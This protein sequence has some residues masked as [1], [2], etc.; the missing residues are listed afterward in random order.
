MALRFV[1][2][3]PGRSGR[4]LGGP[5]PAEGFELS[6]CVLF[7]PHPLQHARAEF[8]NFTNTPRFLDPNTAFGDTNFGHITGQGNS[9]RQ[10]QMGVR[11]MF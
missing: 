6:A 2:L 9:P 5:Q 8:F 4:Q 10:S 7:A 3:A 1:R 11:F